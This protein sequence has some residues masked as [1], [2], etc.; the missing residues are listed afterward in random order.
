MNIDPFTTYQRLRIRVPAFCNVAF[1]SR[2]ARRHRFFRR[3]LGRRLRNRFFFLDRRL[4]FRRL[5]THNGRLRFGCFRFTQLLRWRRIQI[6]F[7]DFVFK[8]VGAAT[9]QR[10]RQHAGYE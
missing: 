7:V 5:G 6:D 9:L 3:R 10:A 2:A 4:F 8:L 1:T